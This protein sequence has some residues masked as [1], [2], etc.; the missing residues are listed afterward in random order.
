MASMGLVYLPIHFPIEN[1][2]NVG[3][4]LPYVDAM[5]FG[6]SINR[7]FIGLKIPPIRYP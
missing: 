2:P 4:F 1:Q 7:R 3:C 6:P 5:G